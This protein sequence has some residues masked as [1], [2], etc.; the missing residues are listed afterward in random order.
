MFN[1]ECMFV[2]FKLL[3]V[4]KWNGGIFEEGD[5]VNDCIGLVFRGRYV[6]FLV[7]M[8]LFFKE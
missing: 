3:G 6:L 1:L 5:V 4:E 7:S 8:F 2:L